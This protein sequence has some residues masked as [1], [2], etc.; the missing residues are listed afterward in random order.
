MCGSAI[1]TLVVH[2]KHQ[3]Y[4]NPKMRSNEAQESN[5]D[6]TVVSCMHELP[7]FTMLLNRS[8]NKTKGE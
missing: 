5:V 1:Y 6:K 2:T 3:A 8:G 7:F 4:S